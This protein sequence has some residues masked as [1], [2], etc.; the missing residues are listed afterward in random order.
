MCN[1]TKVTVVM[2]VLTIIAALYFYFPKS[3]VLVKEKMVTE[4]VVKPELDIDVALR[5]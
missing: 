1:L 3:S 2:V 4:Q 5:K